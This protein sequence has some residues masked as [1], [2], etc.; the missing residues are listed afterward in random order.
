[1]KKAIE[2]IRKRRHQA[3]PASAS[4][5][6]SCRSTPAMRCASAFPDSEI[7]DALFVLERLRARKSPEE[8]K[9][10]QASLRRR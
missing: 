8:L 3:A 6:A 2:H 10:L 5:S 4:S 7:V 1:M 9:K